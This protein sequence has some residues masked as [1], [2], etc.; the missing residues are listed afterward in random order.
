MDFSFRQGSKERL[1]VTGRPGATRSLARPKAGKLMMGM[2]ARVL[3]LVLV[4]AAVCSTGA[5]FRSPNFEVIA[6]SEEIA[7]QVAETAERSREE[8]AISW[9]GK[10]LPRWY[11]PCR[12]TVK[13][14][15][16]GAGGATTFAFDQGEVF[17]WRMTVQG[18]LERVLDSV[19]PHE[20][21]HTIFATHFRRPLPRWADE[22]AASLVEH[23]SEQQRQR[24]MLNQVW[25][26]SR[27]IPIRDLLAMTEYPADMQSV[28]TLYAEGYSL[29]DF[30]VQAGGADGRTRF[31]EFLDDAHERGWDTALR[32]HYS[33]KGINDLDDR[34]TGW[35][36]A[37]SP[38]LKLPP[39]QMYA[40][41]DRGGREDIVV[42]AQSPDGPR[43]SASAQPSPSQREQGFEDPFVTP[44]SGAV[45]AT[46][47]TAV[48]DRDHVQRPTN[49][50]W[51]SA[52]A[53]GSSRA[54]PRTDSSRTTARDDAD[55]SVSPEG[56]W[57]RPTAPRWSDFAE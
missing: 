8:L 11:R 42:R 18:S 33:L 46:G 23:E 27:H 34:W 45:A 40:A 21:S 9:L 10:T 38:E 55:V 6:P 14:G 3:R 50:G 5:N 53:G 31:L 47:H 24:L 19:I 17:G 13:V 51:I 12:I 54:L 37:G 26:S 30:L 20:V 43:R 44:V 36:E 35:V 22:G 1:T 2:E 4:A 15:Q 49:E 56:Q 28:M 48:D 29:A 39:G 52:N 32:Q 7:R 41:T 57:S 16:L 25:K